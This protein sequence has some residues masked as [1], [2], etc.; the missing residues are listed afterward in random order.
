MYRIVQEEPEGWQKAFV[1]YFADKRI[2]HSS[3]RDTAQVAVMK[4]ID[5]Y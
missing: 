5:T 3:F 2:T 4:L 1:I